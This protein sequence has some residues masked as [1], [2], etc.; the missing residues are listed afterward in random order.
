MLQ[1]NDLLVEIGTEELPPKALDT[2]SRAFE[3]RLLH[4]LEEQHLSHDGAVRFAS[5]RR[6]AVRVTGLDTRQP[7][8]EVV[9]QG[10]AVS[11]AFDG[12]GAPT[13]AAQ[14]FARSCGVDPAA[15]RREGPEGKERL[16]FRKTEPGKAAVELL[17]D[18]VQSALDALPIP[19]RMRWGDR[20]AEFVRPVHWVVLLL[21]DDV[22]PGSV[23][24][25]ATGR[26]TRGHRFL[27]PGV[28]DVA[29]PA[30]YE[31]LL[32]EVGKV[33]PSFASRRERI[34]LAVQQTA[35]QAGGNAL[36]DEGLLDEVTALN[37]W[38]VPVL[39]GFDPE[40]LDVPAEALIETM[41]KNQKYFPLVDGVGG[42][43]PHFITISN[44]ESR[45]PSQ[46]RRGNERVIRPRFKDAAFFWQQDRKR[47]LAES[48][49]G[50]RGVV[51]QK[52]LGSLFDKAERN[53]HLCGHIAAIRG[54][55]TQSARRAALLC[56]ADLLSDM[57]GEFP[58]LQGVMGRYYATHS[59]EPGEVAV[60]I[61]EHY[62][63][64]HAGDC[65]PQTT[66]GQALALA[67]RID[68]LVG[69]FA[70]GQK[71]T[72]VKDPYGLRRAALGVLRILIETP[73]DLDLR[74]LLQVAADSLSDKVG[75]AAVV[76]EVFDYIMDRLLGYYAERQTGN[77]IVLSVLSLKPAVPSDIDA[78]IRA[79]AKF[80]SLPEA[81][82]LAAAN[83]RIAN[84]LKKVEGQ[85]VS[86]AVDSQLLQD[87]HEE[88]LYQRLQEMG[89]DV[90]P[91]LAHKDYNG[92]LIRLAALRESVDAFFDHVMV[93]S[94]DPDTRRNRLA[95]LQSIQNL[96]LG[97]A[98]I[99]R[100][101]E[102]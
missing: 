50:L 91:L 22:V 57:V 67:D 86:T 72:G 14:G 101:G 35:E 28:I 78:R 41:Q 30:D 63:P 65:L 76:D 4:L 16:V 85:G 80:R 26:Q 102:A 45:D 77:D 68:T 71:P 55:D 62:L 8:Q 6:L 52:Q 56:K 44:I 58:S 5:P 29:K 94:N 46:V 13:K 79:V 81:D 54:L 7:D 15:L 83:K 74:D 11:A 84:I 100:L 75:T 33:E 27:A 39:G 31:R 24:D 70:I 10:P 38:P 23:M 17:A 98:D 43:L 12:D 51:Y 69:I 42:L 49:E 48:V 82:S 90:Q 19:K 92:A 2:L 3:E 95:M 66:I 34:S 64:R 89:A 73:L 37:E 40:F 18:M 87:P 59:G 61:A 32:R 47:P 93:M 99:A 88:A 53:A 1:K 97:I 25:V 36:I 9:R 96:F 60:A 21:G 20:S